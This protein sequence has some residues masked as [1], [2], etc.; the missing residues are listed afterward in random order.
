[1]TLPRALIALLL[2]VSARH[3]WKDYDEQADVPYIS[4]R[5][6]Q[7]ANDS[8]MEEEDIIYH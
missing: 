3:F 5:K 2:A 4:F 8:I 6:P 1:M 7:R